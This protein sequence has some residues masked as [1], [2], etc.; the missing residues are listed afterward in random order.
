MYICAPQFFENERT[1][2]VRIHNPCPRI[3]KIEG[4]IIWKPRS[5]SS[6]K[7]LVSHSCSWTKHSNFLHNILCHQGSK[8]VRDFCHYYYCLRGFVDT[9]LL[10]SY[11]KTIS[12]LNFGSF[13]LVEF[14]WSEAVTTIIKVPG[15]IYGAWIQETNLR[16]FVGTKKE[17]KT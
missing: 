11:E 3:I 12:S 4:C 16:S 15:S 17:I 9:I 8:R 7:N 1:Q 6:H 2:N 13:V 5:L 14:F 10:L